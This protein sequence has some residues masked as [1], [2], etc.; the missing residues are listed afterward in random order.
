[1]IRTI[2]LAFILFAA[3]TVQTSAAIVSL[4]LD[5]A[6]A[7]ENQLTIQILAP[8]TTTVIGESTTNLSGT[9]TIDLGIDLGS[10]AITGIHY[11]G[12]D[13]DGSD[14]TMTGVPIGPGGAPIDVVGTDLESL[15]VATSATT[16][17]NSGS[18]VAVDHNFNLTG[19]VTA[20]G[21]DAGALPTL[22]GAGSGMVTATQNGNGY[23]IFLNMPVLTT[24]SIG[25]APLTIAGNLQARGFVSVPE[26]GSLFVLSGL[27]GVISF[28]RRRS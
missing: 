19:T 25:G 9:L 4:T 3:S 18:F 6:T 21:Q 8:G 23:D 12:V 13:I 22:N 24:D 1:M 14:W 16:A 26:P 10:G 15:T 11:T 5:P 27:A 7:S 17:V 28:R 20:G 2:A